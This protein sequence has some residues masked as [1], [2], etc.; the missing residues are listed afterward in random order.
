MSPRPGWKKR[1]IW[2]A[3]T[4]FWLAG[5]TALLAFTLR[6]VVDERQVTIVRIKL[7]DCNLAYL[8]DLLAEYDSVATAVL[9]V[10]NETRESDPMG[11]VRD[12]VRTFRHAKRK[13]RK[14]RSVMD[15]VDKYECAGDTLTEA[16]SAHFEA[17]DCNLTEAAYEYMV[18]YHEL[19]D[20][21]DAM[22][23]GLTEKCTTLGASFAAAVFALGVA[24]AVATYFA[25]GA[26][27]NLAAKNA[28]IDCAGVIGDSGVPCL[29]VDSEAA[30]VLD[31][32]RPAL[33]ALGDVVGVDLACLF[34]DNFDE[35][36]PASADAPRRSFQKATTPTGDAVDC[37]AATT[38]VRDGRRLVFLEDV[39]PLRRCSSDLDNQ[40]RLTGQLV[41]EL[42]NWVAP[43]ASLLEQAVHDNEVVDLSVALAQLHEAEALIQSRLELEKLYS[44]SY[45]PNKN[46]ETISIRDFIQRCVDAAR[47]L[48]KPGV[49]FETSVPECYGSAA[50][51][52]RLDLYMLR[53]IGTN[54]LSN[55][56]KHTLDRGRVS[57]DF[58]GDLHNDG[59]LH[60]SVSDT[61]RGIPPHIASRLFQEQVKTTDSR[62]VG[63]GLAS[64]AVFAK[65]AGGDVWL[66]DTHV[67]TFNDPAPG[68]STFCF[69]LPGFVVAGD[70]PADDDHRQSVD[71]RGLPSSMQFYVVEDSS[72]VRRRIVHKMTLVGD[73]AGIDF[74]FHEFST[75]ESLL[76]TISELADNPDVVVSVD[77]NLT[78]HTGGLLHGSDLIRALRDSSFKGII[79]SATGNDDTAIVHQS[80]GAHFSLGKPYPRVEHVFDK[81]ADAY[82]AI[83]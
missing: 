30:C 54:L 22:A 67:P 53:H 5:F 74:T 28:R 66:K 7:N 79:I 24:V 33:D 56:R 20:D 61:G 64:C 63:L 51:F 40:K 48:V 45:D 27:E 23:R 59:L 71:R 58:L 83:N 42:R 36:L 25:V 73:H 3:A 26:A 1:R 4:F 35:L 39:T 49:V 37:M 65:A 52:A 78:T 38:A 11:E 31:A 62:S 9:S 82:T 41:H 72:V 81:L 44:G 68:G 57:F 75:V 47:A 16:L 69:S 60:F 10:Q 29:V 70:E 34:A 50:V 8:G 76:P 19:D 2:F 21:L 55:A 18:S 15:A 43:A 6:C 12:F 46:V 77:E 13:D 14:L 17:E 80:L 32:N